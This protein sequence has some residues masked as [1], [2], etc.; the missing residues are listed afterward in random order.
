MG[1]SPHPF[2]C[3][4]IDS[5]DEYDCG[6]VGYNGSDDEADC[7]GVRYDGDGIDKKMPAKRAAPTNLMTKMASTLF[8]WE[9]TLPFKIASRAEENIFVSLLDYV[10][11]N[12]KIISKVYQAECIQTEFPL[13]SLFQLPS[14]Y[15]G[16]KMWMILFSELVHEATVQGGFRFV[17]LRKSEDSIK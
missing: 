16:E 15:H 8:N 5:D 2:M 9:C 1:T 12:P 10:N 13:D 4:N 6:G 7:G 14:F 11:R 3:D 17:F